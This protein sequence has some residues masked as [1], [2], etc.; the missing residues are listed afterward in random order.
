MTFREKQFSEKCNDFRWEM[1]GNLS[2][3][4]ILIFSV[5]IVEIPSHPWFVG[6]Q[7]HPELRSTVNHPQPLFVDFVKASLKYSKL[8]KLNKPLKKGIPIDG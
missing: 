8:N 4:V 5:E 2:I 6:V 1:S 3:S 7:F